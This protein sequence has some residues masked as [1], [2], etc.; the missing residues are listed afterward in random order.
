MANKPP[1]NPTKQLHNIDNV[2]F[3]QIRKLNLLGRLPYEELYQTAYI[4]YLRAQ[5]N[6]RPEF[7]DLSL[8]YVSYYM[9]DALLSLVDKEFRFRNHHSIT[10]VQFEDSY[11]PQFFESDDDKKLN[12]IQDSLHIL[13]DRERVIIYDF[14]LA[15]NPKR[16]KDLV[17]KLG[18]T[19]QRINQIKNRA[20]EKIR[21]HLHEEGKL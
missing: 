14:Y 5:E 4:G 19:K 18:I 3:Y 17:K 16:L 7:G 9:K 2:I 15:D 1:D 13:S 6:H 10:D 8:T 20:L 12:E 11:T 21:R